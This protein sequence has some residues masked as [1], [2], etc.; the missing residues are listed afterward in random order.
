MVIYVPWARASTDEARGQEPFEA[1]ARIGAAYGVTP[2]RSLASIARDAMPHRRAEIDRLDAEQRRVTL[3]QLE[4]LAEQG[5]FP[6]LKQALDTEDPIEVG[7]RLIAAPERLRTALAAAGVHHELVR[8]LREAF[9][10][11]SPAELSALQPAFVRWILFSEFSFDI[12]GKVPA[13]TAQQRSAPAPYRTAVYMLCD[14][15]RGTEEWHDAYVAA[16]TEVEKELRFGGLAEAGSAWGERDTFPAED[17]AALRFVQVECL[18]GRLESA[19]RTLD[20]RQRSIWLREPVRRQLWQLARRALELL[21]AAQ[22]WR[23][24]SVTSARPVREHVLAYASEADGLWHVDRAERRMER[25]AGDCLEREVLQPLID[26]V[27]LVYQQAIDATQGA[28]LEAVV[29][30]GWPPDVPKQVQVFGR[31][32]APALQAGERV[33]YFLMDALRFEM[34]KDLGQMLETLKL[35]T[36]RVEATATV[37]PTTTPF[38]MAALLPGAETSFGCEERQAELVPTVGGKPTVTVEDRKDRFREQLGDR[39]VDLRLDELLD[40]RDAKLKE[41]LGRASLLVVRSDDIDKA[42][43][44]TNLPSARRFMSSILDDAARVAQRLARAGVTRMVFAADHGYV[45]LRE[46][47]PGDVVKAPPGE[48]RLSKRR[49]QLGSAAGSIEGVRVLSAA[50]V[51]V[52]GPVKDIALATG[53]RVFTA[54]AGYFHEGMSLQECL[55]PVVVLEVSSGGARALGGPAHVEVIYKHPRFIQRILI[56]RLKLSSL[57]EPEMDVRV[58]AVAPGSTEPVGQA[59][60]GEARDPA[61]GLIH[62]RAGVEEAV[63][64]RIQDE[65]SGPEVELQVID[66]G[67]AGVLLGSMKLKNGCLD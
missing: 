39:Y 19:R 62:L 33:A 24:R 48:W 53:F 49:C 14:R 15:L 45:L 10:F 2:V 31:H 42:G 32:V 27:H 64:V 5:G 16:A 18:A 52:H 36:V 44:G 25:A 29:R 57:L 46:V 41:R 30:D 43:E 51:G 7:A 1:Y 56:V 40:A 13:H 59:A 34:G 38:G 6:L 63:A 55:V 60:D 67:G 3:E 26:Q 11:D 65:F 12:E 61:T 20:L 9:G 37:V 35:G 47:P 4:A 50:H 8:L 28:F 21:E 54:G 66:A 22:R 58:I 17:R 23:E